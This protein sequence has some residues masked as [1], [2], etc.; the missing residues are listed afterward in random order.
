MGDN[1]LPAGRVTGDWETPA[2]IN[3]TW[4]F[5]KSDHNW[6]SAETLI[7]SLID[8]AGKGVNYLLNIG[9]DAEGRVPAPS[10]ERLRAIGA[11]LQTNGEAIYGTRGSPFAYE[12]DWGRLTAR[13]GRLY[14]IVTAPPSGPLTLYGLRTLVT[15]ARALA[16][17]QPVP[18][19]QSQSGE[20]LHDILTLPA[21]AWFRAAPGAG[22]ASP[23]VIA[24]DL[25]GEACADQ[26]ILQQPDGGITLF[27]H[28]ARLH[29]SPASAARRRPADGHALF[30]AA[31]GEAAN[32]AIGDH[33][34]IGPGGLI[35]NWRSPEDRV[36]WSFTVG[37]PGTF[38]VHL[39][40]VAAKYRD[41]VGGHTVEVE[42][43]GQ[44]LRGVVA[45]HAVIDGPRRALFA[46]RAT[47]LGELRLPHAGEF[48]LTLRAVRINAE[49]P[50]G[51]CVDAVRVVSQRSPGAPA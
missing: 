2:T 20:G 23:F 24:L 27:A 50:A 34:T 30:A 22:P 43:A 44:T 25:A 1:Q 5:K 8:L 10:A 19:A 41:W 16:S 26:R 39:L 40:T 46:E 47:A 3:H 13:P 37:T 29:V 45:D 6:R 15:A 9:P 51:L 28:M 18:F 14:L 49:D 48:V 42:A 33:L 4:G 31:S 7:A 36:T 12:F 32:Q 38:D 35:E 11:W 21:A 17:G